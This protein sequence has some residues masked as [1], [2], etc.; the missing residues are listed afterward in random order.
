MDEGQLEQLRGQLHEERQAWQSLRHRYTGQLLESWVVLDHSER[1]I[2]R[3][4]HPRVSFIP[5]LRYGKPDASLV[6]WTLLAPAQ[7]QQLVADLDRQ[8]PAYSPHQALD[9]R[10]MIAGRIAAAEQGLRW[11]TL[12][13]LRGDEGE[14]EP[15]ACPRPRP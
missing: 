1:T 8:H 15:A 13:G 2:Q 3:V 5:T 6:N 14:D 10:E 9:V 7:A 11:L 4:D 12:S